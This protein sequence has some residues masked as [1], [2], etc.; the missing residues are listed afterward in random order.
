MLNETLSRRKFLRLS[1]G[2]MGSA[3]ALT[4]APRLLSRLAEDPQASVWLETAQNERIV[5]TVCSLCPAGCGMLARV[6]EGNLVKM[7]GSPMHPVNVG[8]L[9]PKGQ[10]A[11]ELLYNP[12]RLTGPM[13]RTGARGAG[14]WETISWEEA[15]Q[16][17]ADK[18]DGLRKAGHPERAALLYGET[19]GQ[20]RGFLERFMKAIGSP[21]AISHDSLNIEAAKLGAYLTQ[22]VY[23][24][25]AYDLENSNY[26]ISF[27]ASLLE[28][29]R[30]PQRTVS[31]LSYMRRGRATRGKVVVFDPREG[32]SGAKADEWIPIKPGT[33]AALILAMCNVIIKTGRF[34]ADFVHNYAFGFEDFKDEN[35]KNHKGFKNYVL[36]NFDPRRVEQIT[37]VSA[38]TISRIAGEFAG[39]RPAVAI[40]PGKGGLLNGSFGGV[41]TAMAIHCLNALVGSLERPG[42]VLTQRYPNCSDWPELPADP[43]AEAGREAERVDG[44]GTVFPVGRYAYQAVADR[45]LDGYPLE[46][47]FLYDANPVFETPGG[48][49]FVQAFEKIPFIVSF[50]TFMDESAQYADLVL[51]EPT[52]LERW[53]DDY[54][55]GLGYPGVALRQPVLEPLHDTMNT[56]DFFLKVA[57]KMGG[58][59]AEAMP[60]DSFEAL[61]QDRL[62]NIG[63][64]WETLKELGVWITPGYRFARRGSKI[65]V[66]E[67]VG[68]DRKRAPR[69]GYFDF[70]SRELSCILGELS[71]DEL[72]ALNPGVRGDA[73]YLP[74]YEG[75][76][77]E[78]SEEAF[79]LILNVVTLM[80]LGSHSY[81]ANLPTLQEISGMVVGER[82]GSWVEMNPETAA[83]LGLRNFQQVWVESPF[84]R[85]QTKLRLVKSLHPQ[86]VSLPY[87]QGHKAI[88]R[89]A[90]DRGVNGLEIM[91]PASETFTGLAAFTNTRVKVYAV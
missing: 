75:V 30:N 25:P 86:V 62:Q 23:D 38:T 48:A 3:A 88:G 8:A 66:N 42:G 60:W 43:V 71:A 1:A 33:D 35:G 45:V 20:M 4:T 7:E 40:M 68:V 10:A 77:Y 14:Q 37:G 36:E 87:N 79:P 15:I 56:G 32:V 76:V 74:H 26:V 2:V 55:E 82:W 41:S 78:G 49:K 61:L 13:R 54:I 73:L 34:D 58:P 90:K 12:D 17:V 67:V 19:R 9:C 81:N 59:V 89:W 91:N 6:A 85:I 64:D 28:A 50:A 80:S 5:P 39:N 70:Y 16:T 46:A 24:L 53:Q 52:F 21:N 69:D 31:G 83:E 63:T 72:A 47:L 51:P 18:L 57:Q 29:G 65:W 84:G 22:G 44:A 11:P 27:G